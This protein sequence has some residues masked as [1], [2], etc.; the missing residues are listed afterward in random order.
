MGDTDIICERCGKSTTIKA[1]EGKLC[2]DCWREVRKEN[3]LVK[4]QD[5]LNKCFSYKSKS[6]VTPKEAEIINDIMC[7]LEKRYSN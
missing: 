7:E 4:Q 2:L 6:L 3:R 1:E 5:S